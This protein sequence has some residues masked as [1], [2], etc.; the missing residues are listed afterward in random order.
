MGMMTSDDA[1]V[2]NGG[3]DGSA[4][5]RGG[6]AQTAAPAESAAAQSTTPTRTRTQA[7]RSGSGSGAVKR[8]EQRRGGALPDRSIPDETQQQWT[9]RRDFDEARRRD[10]LLA[11][12]KKGVPRVAC[13]SGAYVNLRCERWQRKGKAVRLSVIWLI[14]FSM[15]LRRIAIIVKRRLTLNE[16]DAHMREYDD[17][18][19]EDEPCTPEIT[20][21]D[22]RS[23]I[24]PAV[25]ILDLVLESESV[26]WRI[27]GANSMVEVG[28]DALC[29][30]MVDGGDR[31]TRFK[32]SIVGTMYKGSVKPNSKSTVNVDMED[33]SNNVIDVEHDAISQQVMETDGWVLMRVLE[34]LGGANSMVEVGEDVLSLG[35][36]DGGEMSPRF[37]TSIVIGGHQLEDNL[38]EFDLARSRLGFSSCANFNFT[39]TDN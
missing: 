18:D 28:E 16:E 9:M 10:G 23:G 11:K 5:A 7:R 38:L 24:G 8:V 17:E 1:A 26:Y 31:S 32:T 21:S 12:R 37:K 19:A 27:W 34:D 4:L 6:G 29:L 35:M 13:R 3:R 15:V 20:D 36:V 2:G 33:S 14:P 30:G 39:S 22:R 25:P